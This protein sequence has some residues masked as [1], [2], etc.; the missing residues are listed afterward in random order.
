[1]RF[2]Q[3]I[4]AIKNVNAILKKKNTTGIVSHNHFQIRAQLQ[5]QHTEQKAENK[6]SGT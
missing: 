2:F 3:S 1:M 6:F 4:D 5:M